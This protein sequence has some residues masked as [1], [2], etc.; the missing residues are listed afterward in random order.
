MSDLETPVWS[1]EALMLALELDILQAR[2]RIEEYRK[3]YAA[4]E[5]IQDAHRA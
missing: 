1:I 4:V 2:A 5:E 3:Q